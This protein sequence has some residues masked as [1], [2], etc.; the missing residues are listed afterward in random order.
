MKIVQLHAENFKRLGLVEVT[1]EGNLIKVGGKNGEG[2]SSLLDAIFVALK[3]RAVAPPRPV[4]QGEEKCTIRLD[5][6][7]LIITRSFHEKGG[8]KFTDNIKV[9]DAEGR[10]YGKP[11]EVLSALLGE[12]GFD[13]FAFVNLKPKEQVEKLLEMVP[14][15]VDLDDMREADNSDYMNRRDENREVSRLEAQISAIP[16]GEVPDEIPDRNALTEQLG[17]AA[18]K[19]AEIQREMNR[20]DSEG[21]AVG[22]LREEAGSA[23]REAERLRAQAA[24]LDDKA[25]RL[26]AEA[27]ER[28]EALDALDA[29]PAFVDTEAIRSKLREADDIIEAAKQQQRRAELV[30]ELEGARAKSQEYTDAIAA[31]AQER[32]AALAAAEMPVEGLGI[33]I[34][35]NGDPTLTWE[36]LPFDRDQIST[37]AQ[38]KVSTA[39]GMASN[40]EL[41]V[42]RISDGSLLDEDAMKLLTDMARDEDFQ[43]WVEVV[44]DGGVGIVMEDGYVRGSPE[45]AAALKA[46]ADLEAKGEEAAGE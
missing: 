37:A 45:Q 35:E 9:E 36:G 38:L 19:N 23:T 39:I 7:E 10:R 26:T 27:D 43:L 6:G 12:I 15:T 16:A 25:K 31:R 40:P 28:A 24:E 11:Q 30:A 42:L 5:L 22:N 46:A 17:T 2:K 18:D 44:G 4:R 8:N 34:D 14:L 21:A 33:S 1:P 32:N 13:P 3:G 20:R 41:R 29:V